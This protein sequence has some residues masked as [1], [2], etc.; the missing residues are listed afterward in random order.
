MA[1]SWLW[2]VRNKV[3]VHE[4]SRPVGGFYVS[5]D[6]PLAFG[7]QEVGEV[8]P[9][10]ITG[11]LLA[12]IAFI[13][14]ALGRGICLLLPFTGFFIRVFPLGDQALAARQFIFLIAAQHQF[15]RVLWF[16]DAAGAVGPVADG[17]NGRLGC[18][19]QFAHLCIGDFRIVFQDIGNGVWFVR[20]FGHWRIARPFG[21][22]L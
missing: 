17:I 14:H 9:A 19:D 12:I 10:Q 16:K 4:K 18:A 8:K 1:V 11:G 21:P 3:F 13:F 20:A 7:L 22:D 6:K 15:G 2:S 5:E